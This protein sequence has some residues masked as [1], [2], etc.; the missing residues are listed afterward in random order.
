GYVE[1]RI[2]DTGKGIPEE[3]LSK[4]FDPFFTTKEVGK[5]TGLGLNVAYNIIKKHNGTIDVE[6]T[7]GKGTMFTIRIPVQK[8]V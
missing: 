6:S 3:N 4:I 7:M 2:S 8:K 5:G 1:I